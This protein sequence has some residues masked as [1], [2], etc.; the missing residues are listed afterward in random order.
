M[1][2][3]KSKVR[4]A[5][6]KVSKATEKKSFDRPTLIALSYGF[7]PADS[8]QISKK[9]FDNYRNFDDPSADPGATRE[10][11]PF[12]YDIAEKTS[13][14]RTYLE[15][16]WENTPHPIEISLKKPFPGSDWR[17]PSEHIIGLEI[18]G[19][20]GSMAEAIIV[21]SAI[22]ILEEEGYSDLTIALN[23]IGDKDSVAD[24][25]RMLSNYIRKNVQ[26]MPA[27]LRTEI[28]KSIYSLVRNKDPK[29]EK[30]ATEAPKSMSFLSETSRIHFKE[31]LEYVES[32]DLPYIIDT[33][34]IGCPEFVSHVIFEIR[35]GDTVLANGY[36]YSRLSKKLGFKR[37]L[38]AIGATIAWKKSKEHAPQAPAKPRFYLIQLGFG[39]KI[40]ALKTLETLRKAKI[41][42]IH[43]LT[44]DKMQSQMG[45]AENARVPY[46]LLVG[47]KEAIENSVVVRDTNTRVQET[48]FLKDLPEY[49]KKLK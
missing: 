46:I 3:S 15:N 11:A 48:V 28:K 36:R 26:G 10:S 30:W 22:S 32:F 4:D 21:R 38:P 34:L 18:L 45:S 25:D 31:V 29:F 12:C 41:A 39:A 44:K 9:D 20:A 17:R 42:V 6:R 40:H 37:E 8:P 49:L 27:E 33:S 14:L 23:S 19:F 13:I 1:K 43:S 7:S 5:K 35:Q 2:S 24:Y 16:N 47:Q